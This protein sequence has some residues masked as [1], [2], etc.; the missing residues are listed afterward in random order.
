M[1]IAFQTM[2]EICVN[3]KRL[4]ENE[5]QCTHE[6]KTDPDT[7]EE[8]LISS[9]ERS[10]KPWQQSRSCIRGE[11]DHFLLIISYLTLSSMQ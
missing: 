1:H 8:K 6:D 9:N 3:V 5:E 4:E 2:D 7:V 11:V 10:R